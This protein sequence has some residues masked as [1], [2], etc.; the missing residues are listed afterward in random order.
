MNIKE[1]KMITSIYGSEYYY[2]NYY[3]KGIS[4]KAM[5]FYGVPF[6]KQKQIWKDDLGQKKAFF[7]QAAIEYIELVYFKGETEKTVIFAL[8]TIEN[9]WF[10][11]IIPKKLLIS[12]DY[13]VSYQGDKF[14]DSYDNYRQMLEKRQNWNDLKQKVGERINRVLNIYVTKDEINQLIT[15]YGLNDLLDHPFFKLI[16]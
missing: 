4:P 14:V 15:D 7:P 12:P 8:K 5:F 10:N 13:I 11:V 6:W 16:S 3:L 1:K 9:S 2:Q